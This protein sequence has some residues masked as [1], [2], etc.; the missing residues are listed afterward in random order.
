MHRFPWTDVFRRGSA[1]SMF[2]FWEYLGMKKLLLICITVLSCAVFGP[3][4]KA[5]IVYGSVGSVYVQNFDSLAVSGTSNSWVNNSTIA[6]W[7][8]FN[9]AGNAISTYQA[10]NGSSNT[11]AFYSFGTGTNTERALGAVASGGTYFGSPA[12]GAIAGHVALAFQNGTASSLTSFTI[13]YDGE[14]WRNGGNTNSQS[15]T[16]SYG[17]GSVFGNVATWTSVSSLDFVSPITGTTPSALD[18]NLAANRIADITGTVTGISWNSGD[19]LWLRWTDF[20]DAGNDH[21]LAIDNVRFSAVPEP[22]SLALLGVVGVGGLAARRF[23]KK[24][25]SNNETIA[26]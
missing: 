24:H 8:L 15:L 25:N 23:R 22:T 7:S 19:T 5:D 10:G 12:T 16:F 20:N 4:A 6:G 2:I 17:F 14:Q 1:N 13:T 3:S 21:G 26:A 18:G 9:S 11:G